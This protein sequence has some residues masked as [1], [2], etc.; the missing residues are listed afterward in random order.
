METFVKKHPEIKIEA[1]VADGL[2]GNAEFMDKASEITGTSQ[3]VSKLK[4]TQNILF[5]GEKV[6]LETFFEDKNALEQT[7]LVRGKETMI[8]VKSARL[9]VCAHNKKRVVIALKSEDEDE[10]RYLVASELTWQY[11]DIIELYSLRWLVEVF[12][13]DHKA[14]EG[15]GNMTKQPGEE[16]S[17]RSLTLSL[18]VDHCLMLHPDQVALITNKLPSK[19]VGSLCET[20]KIDSLLAF[21]EK[22]I[23]SDDPESYFKK[24]SVFLKE[25]FPKSNRSTKHMNLK[26]WGNF[27]SSPSLR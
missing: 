11:T 3:I 23:H 8:F 12:I 1:V 13:Q 2:Y 17:Y 10:Y 9:H 18:L 15:W 26:P 21:I 25:H 5:N 27:K 24:I 4:C 7:V 19:T 6:S 20:V 16:G 22:I 14:N